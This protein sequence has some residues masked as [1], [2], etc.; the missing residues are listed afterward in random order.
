MIKPED[1]EYTQLKTLQALESI[2]KTVPRHKIL[3]T[4]CRS[5]EQARELWPS[6]QDRESTHGR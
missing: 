5:I 4:F 3:E 2:F 1:L 6:Y